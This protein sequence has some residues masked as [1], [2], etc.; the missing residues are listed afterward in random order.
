M[1]I[2]L[3][4]VVFVFLF[5]SIFYINTTIY[6]F[7]EP[8]AFSGDTIF[9]PY[10]NLPDSSYRANF[11][12]HSVA[13][14]SVTNGHNTEKDLFDGYT[15]RGYDIAGISNYH[16]ISVYAKPMT[17]LYVPVYEHG[18]NIFKSHYL[19]IN[20]PTVSYFDYPLYQLTSHKQKIIENIKENGAMIAMAHPKFAGGR[21]F[22]DM[23]HLVGYE[24]TEV[25]NHYRI[26]EEY[27]DEALSAGRLTWIMGNDDTHDIV[28]EATFRIWN[29]IHSDVRHPDSVMQ[30]M[31]QGQNYAISSKNELCDNLLESCSLVDSTIS[32]RLTNLADSIVLKGQNGKVVHKVIN[33]DSINYS[34]KATD[35][36][37]RMVAYNANSHLY[38]NPIL[39]IEGASVPLNSHVKAEVNFIKTWLFRIVAF[40]VSLTLLFLIKRI[41]KRRK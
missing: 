8:E 15:E 22:S 5:A 26:S 39:R 11:H 35:S 34:F 10:E 1:K 40:F 36:Y 32:I 38:M 23:Q 27:W 33:S 20:S 7:P 17:D 14:K 29:I 41:W 24:F 30:A 19:A 16:K 6:N 12:A 4:L 2:I 13:W 25:L 28:N 37:V 31:K 21:S 9:N 3:S 18:Y